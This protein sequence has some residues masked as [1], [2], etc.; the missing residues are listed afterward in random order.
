MRR[1]LWILSLVLGVLAPGASTTAASPSGTLAQTAGA[2]G[3]VS[4]QTTLGCAVGRGLDDVRAMALSP[5]GAT[6]Y[7]VAATPASVTAFTV[8]ATT[9][10][11]GQLNLSA[12]CLV[13]VAQ[14]G[15]GG[16]RA[17]TGASAVAVSPDGLNV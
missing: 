3:C 17:L 4:Q 5:D 7:A 2:G 11:L 15:C 16:V 1:R 12:G 10:L 13:S 14:T 6:L 8:D 9:G